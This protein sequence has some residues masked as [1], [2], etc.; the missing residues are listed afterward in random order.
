MSRSPGVTVVIPTWNGA[1]LLADNLP[2]LRQALNAWGGAWEVIVVDDAGQDETAEVVQRCC[3]EAI[4]L[5]NEKNSGFSLTC[6]AGFAQAVHPVVL[7]LN[8]DVRVSDGFLAPLLRHFDDQS[9]FAVTPDIIVEHEQRN[10]GI[11]M[12]LYGK[13]NLKGSFASAEKKSAV[14]ENLYAIGACVAYDRDKLMQLGG[15]AADLYTPYLFED[16]DLSYRAWKR[17]WRSLYEPGGAVRHLSS[18]T[19]NRQ[20]KRKKRTI[21]FCNRFVFHW[22]NL[23]DAGFLLK[24]FFFT[25]LHLMFCWLWLDLVYYRAFGMAVARIGAIR[26]VRLANAPYRRLSDGEILRRTQQG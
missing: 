9:V 22:A 6:N 1:A 17:G 20:G 12:G 5:R 4:L 19:I 25:I 3:P 8:N 11:V 15:Y 16:V 2:P 21:Y 14:R 10:Q 13:G 24:N 18:A 26:K 23:T 7:C